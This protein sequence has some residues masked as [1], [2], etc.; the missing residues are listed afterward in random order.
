MS[1]LQPSPIWSTDIGHETDA[2]TLTPVIIWRKKM[3]KLKVIIGVTVV[4]VSDTNSLFSEVS[5]LQSSI[6]HKINQNIQKQKV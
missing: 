2:D 4:S 1:I 5:V 3:N 6:S